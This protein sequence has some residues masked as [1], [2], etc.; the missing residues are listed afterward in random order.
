LSVRH[1]GLVLD[2]LEAAAPVKL[3]ALILADHC[4]ADGFC[5]PSYRRIAERSCLS[6][7][8]VR[9]HVRELIE[10]GVVAKVRTG[11][12][13]TKDGRRVRITN[14]YRLDADALADRPSLLST[15]AVSIVDTRDHLQVA[16]YGRPRWS[17][18]ATK[19]SVEPSLLTVSG[20]EA[21]DNGDG[22]RR[23]FGADGDEVAG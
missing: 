22:L 23:L 2:H 11:C 20:V 15:A 14:A 1:I 16:I 10:S 17:G 6:E 9:R 18:L 12:V 5:W 21:V 8:S 13:A 4:D 19:P 3:V 7:R